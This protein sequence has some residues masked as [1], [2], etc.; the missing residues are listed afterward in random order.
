MATRGITQK[1]LSK[2]T[3]SSER[4]ISNL[5][6]G[7]IRLSEE[8]ALKLEDVFEDV[9]AEFWLEIENAYRLAFLRQDK[10]DVNQLKFIAKEYQ[11]DYVF[12]NMNL[13]IRE[14]A[15]EMLNLLGIDS[16]DEVNAEINKVNYSFMEDGG[17][18]S[19]IYV[20]LK[21]CEDEF[22]LQNDVD[23]IQRYNKEKLLDDIEKYKMLMFSSKFNL[24]VK[25]LRRLLNMHG[26][27]LVVL[28]AVPTSK[29][30]GASSI[31]ENIPV[32]F[33]SKRFKRLDTFYFAFV[34]ELSHIINEDFSEDKYNVLLDENEQELRSNSF[35]RNFLL[36]KDDYELFKSKHKTQA[37]LEEEDIIVFAK[38]QKV[39][40]DIVL[41]FLEH[42]KI[43]TDYSRF[44]HLKS[45]I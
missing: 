8:F 35:A 40:P 6:N 38:E 39:I 17:N 5:I 43:I 42:D 34:H 11:F 19:A 22:Y 37:E 33:L 13:N 31:F 36:N 14:Q 23:Q 30:R 28:E 26:I 12:K 2:L 32:I 4:H 16:F 24:A 25:N 15:S 44:H 45:K 10:K 3:E 29:V 18:K 9:K 27:G 7:K 1:D 21:L 41:G 20:W